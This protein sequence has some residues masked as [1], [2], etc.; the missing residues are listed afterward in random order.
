MFFGGPKNL[1][2][3]IN[4]K[5]H[6]LRLVLCTNGSTNK[7][8][9]TDNLSKNCTNTEVNST[10]GSFT[11]H[12]DSKGERGLKISKNGSHYRSKLVHIGGGG[13][14]PFDPLEYIMLT[15]DRTY[16]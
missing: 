16:R 6:K 15:K 10:K 12:V 3:C 1:E 9:L 4:Q 7:T 2:N 5:S 13:V 8:A 14:R 11:N